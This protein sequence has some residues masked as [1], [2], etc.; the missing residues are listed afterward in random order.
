MT[1]YRRILQW[2]GENC[3]EQRSATDPGGS[4]SWGGE[5]NIGAADFAV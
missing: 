3:P 2:G 5:I 4:E 1:S